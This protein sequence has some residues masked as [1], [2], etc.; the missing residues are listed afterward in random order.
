MF[1]LACIMS[2]S[3]TSAFSAENNNKTLSITAND[4]EKIVLEQSFSVKQAHL[5]SQYAKQ[6]ILESKGTFDTNLNFN[7]YYN[8]D[9]SEKPSQIFG[10]R[11]DTANVGLSAS[12]KFQTGTETSIGFSTQRIQ[13][14]DPLAI[15]NVP[16]FPP[17]AIYEPILSFT[18]SQPLLKNGGGYI[19]RRNVSVA[20]IG[21]LA[22]ELQTSREIENIVYGALSDYWT[23]VLNRR[24]I[25]AME[26]SV[27]FAEEFLK[28]TVSEF[29]LGTAEETDLLAAKANVLARKDQFLA[30]KEY[31]RIWE[32]SLRVRL[33]LEPAI[34]IANKENVPIFVKLEDSENTSIEQALEQRR[35]YLASKKELESRDVSLAIAKNTI[36]PS[37]DLYTSLELN[38]IDASFTQATSSLNSPNLMV[39]LKFSVPI[40]NRIARA[41]RNKA[42]IQKTSALVA[43]KDIENRIANSVVRSYQEIISRKTIVI[44]S[45][46]ALD[47][48]VKKLQEE[49]EKYK[50][51]RSSSDLIVRYQDDA[52]NAERDNIEAWLSY[53]E[54][55]LRFR[56]A[57]G[58]LLSKAYETSKNKEN[59]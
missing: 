48:Q 47:L 31:E 4:V 8:L 32:E 40:E 22:T 57:K 33:G 21:S 51:G 1:I 17:D 34:K 5:K 54:A 24:H 39:G 59:E 20:E 27:N 41:N 19:D 7:G 11:I 9:N 16:V 25:K 15:N 30:A 49:M 58:N 3:V 26:K 45:Q 12:H 56:L 23:L 14:Y 42:K 28:T 38:D 35:D 46:E 53:E 52:V 2:F 37:L 29:K 43:L 55:V 10:D 44:Q 36:W 13:Y 6:S 50:M 18:I